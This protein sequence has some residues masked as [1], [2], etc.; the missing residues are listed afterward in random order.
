MIRDL[1]WACV[2]CGEEE[3]LRVDNRIETCSA[4]GAK[5]R[6]T[7]G[8]HIAIEVQGR[9]VETRTAAE[10]SSQLPPVTPTGKAE[11]LVRAA[12][13]DLTVRGYGEYLGRVEKFGNFHFGEIELSESSL[14]F[15]A[16]EGD[17]NFEWPLEDITAV[18]P[19]STALQ[20]K[21]RKRRVVSIKFV[22]SSSRLWEERLQVALRKHYS[23]REVIDFQPRIS[24]R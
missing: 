15:T 10:W 14:K 21:V 2:I 16:R 18:Q 11:C 22:N 8:A 23:G 7:R 20:V 5:Y 3:A 17:H 4:C 12:E 6:R 9:G 19:S 13:S 24:L 1:L